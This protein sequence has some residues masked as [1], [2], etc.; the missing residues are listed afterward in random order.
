M[1]SDGVGRKFGMAPGSL[2]YIGDQGEEP[3]EITVMDYTADELRETKVKSLDGCRDYISKDS[4]TW[5]NIS[6]IHSPE[7]IGEL[8]RIFNLHPLMLEDVLNTE[9]RPKLDDYEDYLFVV[10]K[11]IGYDP[12]SR[13]LDREQVS[14][15]IRSGLVISLQEKPGDVFDPVRDRIR[16]SKGRI[17]KSGADYLAYALIDM[18]VDHYFTILEQIGEQIEILQDEVTGEPGPE[19]VQDIHRCKHQVIFMRKALWPVREIISALLR[20]ESELISSDVRPYLR[21]VYDHTIQVVDTVETFRDI[22]SGVLDIYL[23]NVSNRMNEVMKVLT[24][25]A[26]IFIPLTFLAGVYGMNFEYMPELAWP[27]AYPA[28]WTVFLLI[29]AGLFF[30]FKRKKW[31]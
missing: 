26:T 7:M 24:V 12:D 16:R 22:L 14:M 21:D 29:F 17:R 5:I 31:I 23:S 15:V 6:G 1:E 9:T 10:L 27:W 19:I 11:M 20:E 4:V 28:V 3:I 18:V 30:W 25:I 2:V 8:G 13:E